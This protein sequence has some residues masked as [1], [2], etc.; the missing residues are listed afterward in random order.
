MGPVT[1]QEEVS[2]SGHINPMGL[3][4]LLG[5]LAPDLSKAEILA[6]LHLSLTSPSGHTSF[7]PQVWNLRKVLQDKHPLRV[8][9]LENQHEVSHF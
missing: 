3:D 1:S 9:S 2:G 6:Q 8:G 4:T 7:I 5:P